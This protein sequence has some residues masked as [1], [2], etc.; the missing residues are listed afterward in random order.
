MYYSIL[1]IGTSVPQKVESWKTV[2]QLVSDATKEFLEC[3]A[4]VVIT[5]AL[6]IIIS[7]F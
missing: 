6:F 5:L 2:R 7:I 1:Q 3:Y 4:K